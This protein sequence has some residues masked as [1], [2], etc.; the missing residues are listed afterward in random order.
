MEIQK[1]FKDLLEL[2]VKH[3]VEFVLVGAYALAFHGAPRFTGDL[4]L[5]IND[6][7]T[8]KQVVQLGHPPVR[9]DILTSISG[10]EWNIVDEGK[11]EGI[12]QGIKLNFIGLKEFLINKKTLGR[13]KDFADIEALGKLNSKD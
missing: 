3:K 10:L 6:F 13:H 1:D 4:D 5:T 9:I 7:T 11:I 2:F 8:E 12:C